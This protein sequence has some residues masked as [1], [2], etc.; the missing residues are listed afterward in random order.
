MEGGGQ[1][2][3]AEALISR[4]NVMVSGSMVVMREMRTS[5][6][7]EICLEIDWEDLLMNAIHKVSEREEITIGLRF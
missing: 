5:D 4:C 6:G 2:S 1:E 3:K 7:F